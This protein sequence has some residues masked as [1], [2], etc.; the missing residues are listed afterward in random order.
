MHPMKVIQKQE[1]FRI[2]RVSLF[3][4]QGLTFLLRY[5]ISTFQGCKIMSIVIHFFFTATF[6]FMLLEAIHTYALVAFVVK[7]NGM[8]TKAQNVIAGWLLSIAVILIVAAIQ[9]ENYGGDYHCWLRID[10]PLSFGQIVPTVILVILIFTVLEAAGAADYRKLP[11]LDQ[12]QYESAKIMQRSNLVIMPLVFISW[13]IGA[14]SEYEQDVG[15]YS[16]F[17]ILNAVLG[18]TVFLFHCS[19]N[20]DVREKLEGWYD[21]IIK[22]K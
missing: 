2:F 7:K 3:I 1:I 5:F 6:M 11:G 18:I 16:V 17:T 9:Y 14:M 10:T 8:L 20:E 15:L 4:H 12:D 19:G 13:M 21:Q 22:R